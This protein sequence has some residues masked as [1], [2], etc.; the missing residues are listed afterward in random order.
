MLYLPWKITEIPSWMTLNQGWI[1]EIRDLRHN[2]RSGPTTYQKL[3]YFMCTICDHK[4]GP[5]VLMRLIKNRSRYFAQAFDKFY[6]L[7]AGWIFHYVFEFASAW[8]STKICKSFEV[9]WIALF[10]VHTLKLL[11]A[12]LVHFRF[13]IIFSL[14]WKTYGLLQSLW[15]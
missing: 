7:K 15:A 14:F 9:I 4:S 6:L 10:F 8:K 2:H 11:R 12:P 1:S 3:W 13:H 5:Q